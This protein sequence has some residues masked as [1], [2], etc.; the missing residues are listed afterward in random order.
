MGDSGWSSLS[1]S[2][3][4]KFPLRQTLHHPE[5]IN[6]WKT[7]SKMWHETVG[8]IGVRNDQEEVKA[9]SFPKGPRRK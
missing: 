3:P 2:S 1:Y 6:W 5:N 4:F 9:Y 7:D 8:K